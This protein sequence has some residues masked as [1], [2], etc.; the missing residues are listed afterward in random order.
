M[1]ARVRPLLSELHAHTTWS[2]GALSVGELADLYGSNGFDVLCVTDH[3]VR[4]DDP[5]LDPLE[6]RERGVREDNWDVYLAEIERE[7]VRA[8]RRYGL[9]VLPGVELTYNDLDPAQAAHA[10]AVGLRTFVPV[11]DGLDRAIETAVSAGAALIAAHPYDAEPPPSPSRLTQ[12]YARDRDGL[13]R[14]VHRFELFNRTQLFGWVAEA[15]LP[16]VASGDFHELEHLVGWKTLLPCA[17]NESAI[18]GYLRSGR[19]AY[20]VR[21]EQTRAAGLAA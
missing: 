7:A 2:D 1:R 17:A 6:W 9:L 14:L 15:G 13:G 3:V 5:W 4:S 19:P 8:K 20:L 21:L 11:D 18:V 12:R 16:T 10:V